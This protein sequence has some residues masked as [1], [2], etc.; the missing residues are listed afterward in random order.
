[1]S[2]EKIVSF[3]DVYKTYR[4]PGL[5]RTF[6]APALDGLSL[7]L[8][9][10]EIAG[11]LGLNGAG[12]T[13]I[14]KL[15]TGLL[16]PDAGSISV[17]GLPPSGM[18]AKNRI[19]FLP[20]L[21]YFH[22]SATASEALAYYAGL[23]GLNG[24]AARARID[25]VIG[26]VGLLPHAGKRVSEFSKGMMQ[27]L[28]VAQ[29]VVHDPEL[30]ILDEPVSGLD[31]LAIHEI[32]DLISEFNGAGKTVFLSSHSISELEKLS[33]RVFIM[34]KG[35]LAKTIARAQWE[36]TPGGLEEIFVGTVRAAA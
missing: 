33:G 15:M 21:P 35:R 31:P 8:E 11:L 5:L 36:S 25:A 30:L 3:S 2:A 17:F 28:G 27:R 6:E 22:P 23:S 26:K 10:G 20:E 24:P 18:A 14:M 7:E 9:R 19:G 4:R 32:R 13:T 16:F 29:A 1:M 34:V 12:K